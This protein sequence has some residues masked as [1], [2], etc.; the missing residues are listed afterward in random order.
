MS[1]R[2]TL[3]VSCLF[4]AIALAGYGLYRWP[5]SWS[6]RSSF[7]SLGDREV[8]VRLDFPKDS[9][10]WDRILGTLDYLASALLFV[11]GP[12]FRFRKRRGDVPESRRAEW[13]VLDLICVAPS[14][15]GAAAMAFVSFGAL[16][17]LFGA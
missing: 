2:R 4:G 6:T 8:H 17:S 11:A 7:D 10:R 15:L 12:V 13:E 3:M 14:V 16:S 5:V 1:R 9:G